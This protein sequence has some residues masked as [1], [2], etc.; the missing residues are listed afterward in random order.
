MIKKPEV[1]KSEEIYRGWYRARKDTLKVDGLDQP[2]V[3]DVIK[4]GDGVGVL[5]FLDKDTLL[6]ARQYRHP[7]E[8]C[9]LELIQ[10]GMNKG[11][12][13]LECG[14]RELMEETGYAANL[15]YLTGNCPLPCLLDMRT[16]AVVATNLRKVAEPLDD[17]LETMELV[18]MPFE[19]VLSEVLEGLHQ[20]SILKTAVMTYQLKYR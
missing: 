12:T 20:D 3:Y 15:E 17:P 2:Y 19:R 5:A 9:V 16:H 8:E 1:I 13:P 10:G 4:P 18:K 14:G 11:E 6:L 7:L